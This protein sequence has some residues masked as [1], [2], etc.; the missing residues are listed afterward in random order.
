MLFWHTFKVDINVILTDYLYSV[1]ELW[2]R[3]PNLAS[4]DYFVNRRTGRLGN[5]PHDYDHP[6]NIC[7]SEDNDNFISKLGTEVAIL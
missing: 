1:R 6:S 3:F 2:R 7:D 4:R 5:L